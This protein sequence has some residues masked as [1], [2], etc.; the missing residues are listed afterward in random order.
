MRTKFEQIYNG[1]DR[2]QEISSGL[3]QDEIGRIVGD[4]KE[5]VEEISSDTEREARLSVMERQL[6]STHRSLD[7]TMDS[8]ST[9][10]KDEF[11]FSRFDIVIID[12]KL[13]RAMNRYSRGGFGEE[14]LKKLA[15]HGAL[16]ATCHYAVKHKEPW[17][18]NDIK[19]Q[20]PL[21]KLAV[22]L[23]CWVHGTF[24]LYQRKKSGEMELQGLIHGARDK[25]AFLSG[26]L[27]ANI[28]VEELKRLAF[29]INHAI[30][31]ARLAYFEH[32]VMKIQDVIGSTRIE[33]SR[34]P[35]DIG[36]TRTQSQMDHVLDTIIETVEGSL[37]GILVKEEDQVKSFSFRSCSRETIPSAAVS[38]SPRP[39]TG[40]M[41]RALFDG[42]SVIENEVSKRK[43]RLDIEI[44]DLDQEIHTMMAVPLIESYSDQGKVRKNVIGVIMV[45]N[46]KD[47]KNRII[48]TDYEGNEGGFS[49][50]DCRILESISPHIETIISNTRRHREVHRLS[51]MDGLTGLANH[52]HFINDLLRLEFLRAQRYGIP[53]A[54]LL[55]DIDHFKVFNDIFGHQVGDMVLSEVAN[56]MWRNSRAV[57][58]IGRY[59][60]E[61]FG[62]ILPNT[63]LY[64]ARLYAE[65]IR[66]LLRETDFSQK[67]SDLNLFDV[68]EAQKRIEA[69]LEIRDDAIKNARIAIMKRHF[70]IDIYQTL[71]LIK[72]GKQ[73]EAR[74]LI[75]ASA[76]VSLSL[77]LAVYPFPGIS[78]QGELLT[79][80]DMLL[81][82]AKEKGRDR[83]ECVETGVGDK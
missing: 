80:A 23:D 10:I 39:L 41:S 44:E 52:S 37:G 57:D 68:G 55:A 3:E 27:L 74:D 58:H 66:G 76:K 32:G 18:V 73:K 63:S 43:E 22:E 35:E 34:L 1:L 2:I 82:Q 16:E 60:G 17:I 46:K 79:I 40:L 24:P 42:Y 48:K 56:I 28:Q 50:L 71:D 20:D 78:D 62:I 36:E 38:V 65:K 14:D 26:K 8:I 21:W 61:E 70:G 19:G 75:T 47:S 81:L 72:E 45:F 5:T 7:E 11:E 9:L 6:F 77:G 13:K 54:L 67:I 25:K 64:D 4:L 12:P 49:S 53:L 51:L 59:G 69:I 30:Y 31:E 33:I 15:R 29:A 83:V